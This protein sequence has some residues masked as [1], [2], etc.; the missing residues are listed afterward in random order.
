MTSRQLFTCAPKPIADVA[1]I[2]VDPADVGKVQF[3]IEPNLAADG[4][5]VGAER[6][7]LTEELPFVIGL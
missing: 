4:A 3:R 6:A 2:L 7:I 5:P 1:G